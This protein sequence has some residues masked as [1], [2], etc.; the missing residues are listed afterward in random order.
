[1]FYEKLGSDLLNG[2][3]T[4]WQRNNDMLYTKFTT[5]TQKILSQYLEY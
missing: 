5:T 3:Q 4:G 1:M 2:N